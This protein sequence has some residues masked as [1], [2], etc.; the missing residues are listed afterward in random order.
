MAHFSLHSLFLFPKVSQSQNEE[1][2][3]QT[4]PP[5]RNFPSMSFHSLVLKIQ[6][7]VVVAAL[8]SVELITVAVSSF[9][10]VN[11]LLLPL[12]NRLLWLKDAGVFCLFIWGVVCF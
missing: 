12:C 5:N 1:E 9:Q 6:D 4:D 3:H 2:G 7:R 11:A 8:S 10:L